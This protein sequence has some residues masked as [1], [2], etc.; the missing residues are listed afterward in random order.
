M[1]VEWPF[2]VFAPRQYISMLRS[3]DMV[4][5]FPIKRNAAQLWAYRGIDR[6]QIHQCT[7]ITNT[8]PYQVKVRLLTCSNISSRAQSSPNLRCAS[9]TG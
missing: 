3:T 8:F 6:G 7:V 4:P 5:R 1:L 9:V 2:L